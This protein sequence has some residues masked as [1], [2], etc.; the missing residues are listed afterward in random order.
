MRLEKNTLKRIQYIALTFSLLGPACFA[1][2]LMFSDKLSDFLKGFLAG[3][4][5]IMI[6]IWGVY[7]VWCFIKK[8]NPYTIIK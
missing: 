2:G 8:R 1:I 5:I 3:L 6:I 7:M 4:S